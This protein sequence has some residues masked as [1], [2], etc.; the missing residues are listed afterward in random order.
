MR[1][2][3]LYSSLVLRLLY[4]EEIGKATQRENFDRVIEMKII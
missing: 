4:N 2:S 3:G 1:S